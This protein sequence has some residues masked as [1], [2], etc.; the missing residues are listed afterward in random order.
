M[1]HTAP[2][3]RT[4]TVRVSA[5]C[6]LTHDTTAL[7]HV[8]QDRYDAY[9]LDPGEFLVESYHGYIAIARLTG[10]TRRFF[11]I[12]CPTIERFEVETYAAADGTIRGRKGQHRLGPT[13][14]TRPEN[15]RTV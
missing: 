13:M 15:L 4:L 5:T 12:D 1:N 3:T 8:V 6:W 2:T 10:R 7:R 14:A 9:D 11:G